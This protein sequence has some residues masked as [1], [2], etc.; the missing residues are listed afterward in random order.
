MATA[1]DALKRCNIEVFNVVMIVNAVSIK[2]RCRIIKHQPFTWDI[3]F[4]L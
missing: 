4:F 2:C 3:L 1:R